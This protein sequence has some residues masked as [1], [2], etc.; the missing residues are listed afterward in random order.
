MPH[1][2]GVASL[3]NNFSRKG[4]AFPHGS[5]RSRELSHTVRMPNSSISDSGI[6]GT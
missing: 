3:H 6:N 5:R 1:R 4:I 2:G